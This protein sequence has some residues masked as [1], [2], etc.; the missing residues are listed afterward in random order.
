MSVNTS[1]NKHKVRPRSVVR[2]FGPRS[3]IV[4]GVWQHRSS[5]EEE[6]SLRWNAH[7]RQEMK[8]EEQKTEHK[9]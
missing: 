3:R 6:N 9:Q 8:E 2:N 4:V 1:A 7:T 5:L